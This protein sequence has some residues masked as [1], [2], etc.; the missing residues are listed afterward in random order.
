MPLYELFAKL[1]FNYFF[2]H[3]NKQTSNQHGVLTLCS[4]FFLSSAIMVLLMRK[5]ASMVWHPSLP[6]MNSFN[7]TK[8]A[9]FSMQAMLSQDYPFLSD[10]FSLLPQV[11]THITR[12]YA[13]ASQFKGCREKIQ[14]HQ[15][16][17]K[18]LCRIL[19]FKV[20]MDFLWV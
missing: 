6:L 19:Y 10:L 16:I 4:F 18:D 3:N 7:K 15:N 9:I 17:I 13:V 5:G 20:I 11:C 12:C 14:E 1:I 2:K 8:A